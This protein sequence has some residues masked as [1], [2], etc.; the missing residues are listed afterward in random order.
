MIEQPCLRP[1]LPRPLSSDERK[2]RRR[3]LGVC[4]RLRWRCPGIPDSSR[5]NRAR[6]DKE[7]RAS[8][9]ALNL[10]DR[11]AAPLTNR[12]IILVLAHPCRVIPAP[13]TLLPVS[14]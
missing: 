3:N 2:A 12:R 5:E 14:L 13:L 9:L 6:N 4:C 1:V 10:L 11:R 8:S 7:T